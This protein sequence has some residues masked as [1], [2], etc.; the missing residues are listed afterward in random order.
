MTQFATIQLPIEERP[1][2]RIA[3]P[4]VAA[5]TRPYWSSEARRML[6]ADETPE[7]LFI[8]LLMFYQAQA[9]PDSDT[10]LCKALER[11]GAR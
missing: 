8:R 6:Q 2:E 1:T 10:A 3:A 7:D 11:S 5:I 4:F 9:R